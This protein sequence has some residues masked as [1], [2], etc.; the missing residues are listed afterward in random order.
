MLSR[1][2]PGFQFEIS[3]EALRHY[4]ERAGTGGAQISN[5]L[6][7]FCVII[8]LA[9]MG[10]LRSYTQLEGG[11]FI[12]DNA[13][14]LEQ[15]ALRASGVREKERIALYVG[16]LDDLCQRFSSGTVSL[17]SPL[18][19][20]KA[21]FNWL[22]KVKPARYKPCG[23]YLF[24][25]VIDA[26]TDPND[27]TVGNCLGLTLLYNCLLRKMDIM[28]EALYLEDG[29]GR[30]PHVLTFLRIAESPI[31]VENVLRDGFD[32]K[33]HLS[34]TLRVRWGD[35]ELVADIHLSQGNELFKA[36]EF[37]QALKSYNAALHFN[38]KYEKAYLNRLILIDKMKEEKN[39]T[40]GNS[41][42]QGAKDSSD[43]K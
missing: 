16:K 5:M 19:R 18:S 23:S 21:L 7:R 34:N 6:G 36:G 2:V 37:A 14:N 9:T 29:F 27:Q 17:S 15:E 4:E 13:F 41:T 3:S 35:R 10:D 32:Y 40:K 24:N 25:E 33:G 39:G 31:D 26:Q 42:G 11:G 20:A 28:A 22:W 8:D 43:A 38:P 12:K 1:P 30:G